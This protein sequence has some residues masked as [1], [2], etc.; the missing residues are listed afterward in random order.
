MAL[1]RLAALPRRLFFMD[2]SRL[3]GHPT[4]IRVGVP[5]G[6]FAGPAPGFCA[7]IVQFYRV[8]F[9]PPPSSGLPVFSGAGMA[10]GCSL[11]IN[12]SSLSIVS[13]FVGD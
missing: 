9:L 12:I 10:A 11:I 1:F 7:I 4:V 8:F 3:A 2:R 13:F 6:G 5:G